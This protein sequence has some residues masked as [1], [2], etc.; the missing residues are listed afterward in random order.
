[1]KGILFS[2]FVLFG[3]CATL[4]CQQSKFLDRSKIKGDG[5]YNSVTVFIDPYSQLDTSEISTDS[6]CLFLE[7]AL[8][9]M[10]TDEQKAKYINHITSELEKIR[11]QNSAFKL[12]K[13]QVGEQI[14]LTRAEVDEIGESYKKRAKKNMSKAW[15]KLGIVLQQKF[16]AAKIYGSNWNW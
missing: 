7:L 9:P 4:Y 8:D 16:P 2:L 11:T 1:M 14:C 5:E 13:V 3:T 6:E 10:S 12:I 15:D